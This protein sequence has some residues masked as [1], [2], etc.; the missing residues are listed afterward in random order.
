LICAAKSGLVAAKVQA[1]G[2]LGLFMEDEPKSSTEAKADISPPPITLGGP[3]SKAETL[4]I[5]RNCI[6]A[7]CFW[8]PERL[9]GNSAWLEH[10]PFAFWIVEALRPRVVVELGTL[11]GCSYFALCQAVKQLELYTRCYAV[12]TW[13]G[14]KH[15]GFY[16]EDVFRDL[17]SYHDVR[18]ASFSTLIRSTFDEALPHFIDHTIDLLHID[19]WHDYEQV[20][21]DFTSW[22]SKMSDRG[23]VLFHDINV[24]ERG[25]GVARLWEELCSDF[26]HFQ[27]LHGYGLGV[28]GVGEN[29]PAPILSLFAAAASERATSQVRE[30]YARLGGTLSLHFANE[31]LTSEL[32]QKTADMQALQNE[33]ARQ[34]REIG[35]LQQKAALQLAQAA[36]MEA[37]LISARRRMEELEI[38]VEALV[39]ARAENTKLDAAL[40]EARRESAE[41]Q[42][43]LGG[44]AAELTAVRQ[45]VAQAEAAAADL[46]RELSVMRHSAS[47]R[48][49]KPLRRMRSGLDIPARRAAWLLGRLCRAMSLRIGG[50]RLH[51]YC[52]RF[53]N[54][55]L[56]AASGLF[57]R[58]WYL[59]RNPDVRAS[60]VNPLR[61]YI[62]HG[63]SEGRDPNP[64]FD[65]DW[66]LDQNRDVRAAGVN[67]LVHYLRHGAAEGRDPNPSFDG[68]WYLD[69]NRDVRAAG[70]NPL[71]HYLRH[72]AAERRDPNPVF[73][74]GRGFPQWRGQPYAANVEKWY[75]ETEPE[76]SIVILNWNK[77]ALTVQCLQHLWAH[78]TG[79]RYEIIVC[80]NGSALQDFNVLQALSGRFRL[81]R[82]GVN[83]FF[84]EGNN[85]GAQHAKGEFLVFLNNDAFVTIGWLEPLR[86]VFDIRDNAGAVGP[87]FVYPDGRL[88]EA[89]ARI[90]QNGC[91]VQVGKFGSP[92]DAQYNE[93][94]AVDYCSAACLM[95]RRY[96]FERV[97]GFDL[98][99]DPAYYEDVDLCFKIALLGLRTYYCPNS[100]VVHLEHSTAGDPQTGLQ[101]Q[102]IVEINRAKFMQRWGEW[103]R[104]RRRPD[105]LLD[106]IQSNTRRQSTAEPSVGI[107]ATYPLIPGGGE[108]Y[109]LSLAEGLLPDARVILITPEAY[110]RVR[111]LTMARELSLDLHG[112]EICTLAEAHKMPKLDVF[113]AIGN[114]VLPSVAGLGR[115]NVYICQFPFPMERTAILSQRQSWDDYELVVVYSEFVRSHMR[116]AS[117]RIA[118]A[119]KSI[120]IIAPPVNLVDG[121]TTRKKNTILSV[122][123][124]F[125]GGHTKRHDVM[126]EAFRTMVNQGHSEME[127]HIAGAL[128]PEQQH[129]EYFLQLQEMARGL[130]VIFHLNPGR[131]ELIELYRDALVYWHGAGFGIDIAVSPE[132]CEHFGITVVEA[133]SAGCI[134]V[135]ADQGGPAEL[136][137]PGHTG[138]YFRDIAEL[139]AI[140]TKVWAGRADP[141]VA[142]IATAAVER[143]QIYAKANFVKEWQQLLAVGR[144]ATGHMS[145]PNVK[146]LP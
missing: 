92:D 22:R 39:A 136:V 21:H 2:T 75:D 44:R 87:K 131:Q 112:L 5:L 61:H 24:R 123:R 111:L 134:P 133:M 4:L 28:L 119:E 115:R 41:R 63:A 31:G 122:G 48:I 60:G 67:P 62:R 72:G 101:L 128:H 141:W 108:M 19:G 50:R 106:V 139:A 13:Q 144:A 80:D 135:V 15:T 107:L 79:Y 137:D 73:E 109:L 47:W 97:L 140:T 64:L 6:A 94:R 129:R 81:L 11:K 70:M 124:I 17:R 26:P 82:I 30:A 25:F 127:L 14:D 121:A 77:S 7:S 71:R 83:R 91:A 110:S 42:V 100:T 138:F 78:T 142:D 54:F 132:K 118:L 37:E 58:N 56:I 145:L 38:A 126:I 99:W 46:Q 90:E 40:T 113:V 74:S 103:M 8:W 43:A 69:R 29:L 120:Q 114:T 53:A 105:H 117:R 32:T 3:M 125:I 95:V 52:V 130:P 104:E 116:A 85:L 102:N 86:A 146:V 143:A 34:S 18:Y 55:K 10:A 27:F 20:K 23:V 84:G 76:I 49:T 88:Q 57:D 68:D 93:L 89:G 33:A 16:G 66:Y 35:T 12:D 1:S 98:C 36:Q 51:D 65:S 96:T 45:R 59:E 9:D